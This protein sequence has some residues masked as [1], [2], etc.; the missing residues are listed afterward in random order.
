MILHVI[1][2]TVIIL[3]GI[4][5]VVLSQVFLDEL[6]R[7]EKEDIQDCGCQVSSGFRLSGFELSLL[8]ELP[9]AGWTP[10]KNLI[11]SS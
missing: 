5:L 9:A 10:G 1:S 4:C 3:V 2:I 6:Y 8:R 11:G 7:S